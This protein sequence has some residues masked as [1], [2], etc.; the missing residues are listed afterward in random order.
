[1][2]RRMIILSFVALIVCLMPAAAQAN[3][4]WRKWQDPKEG[5][6]SIN[7]PAGWRVEGGLVR[8]APLDVRLD[9]LVSSP[10]GLVQI[11]IGDAMIPPFVVPTQLLAQAGFAEGRWYSPGYGVNFLVQRY[12][13]ASYFMTQ[14]YL[15]QQVG[16]IQNVLVRVHRAQAQQISQKLSQ[17]GIQVR[18][19]MA[20]MTFQTRTNQGQYNGYAMIQTKLVSMPGSQGAT[21][22][23]SK[24][25]AYLADPRAEALAAAVYSGV[26]GGFQWNPQWYAR[27]LQIIGASSEIIHQADNEILK[28]IQDVIKNRQQA[29]DRANKKWDEYIRGTR[30]IIGPDGKP[31]EVQDGFDKYIMTPDGQIYGQN[32]DMTGENYVIGQDGNRYKIE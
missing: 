22:E 18:V 16:H 26:V 30:T 14:W 29:F 10:D 7:V 6:F 5:A 17:N 23:V 28:I 25:T 11:R 31:H 2:L 12:L 19:D 15:P 13:P 4:Q 3:L 32:H 20:D 1:M 21:W 8:N 9:V 27:Q 24:M